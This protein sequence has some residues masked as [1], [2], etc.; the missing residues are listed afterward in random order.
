MKKFY[1]HKLPPIATRN[2]PIWRVVTVL[3]AIEALLIVECGAL[4]P[5]VG[6]EKSRK[7][8]GNVVEIFRDN[9]RVHK[10]FL[11]YIFNFV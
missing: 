6:F 3:L 7:N 1:L 9:L 11:N 8:P 5:H 4:A 2:G 10:F